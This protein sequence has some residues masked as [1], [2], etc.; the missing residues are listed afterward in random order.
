MASAKAKVSPPPKKPAARPVEGGS[1][2]AKE[3][4]GYKWEGWFKLQLWDD[5][6]FSSVENISW[7][8]AEG[9]KVVRGVWWKE[10][11]RTILSAKKFSWAAQ[12]ILMEKKPSLEE[13][14]E[15]GTHFELPS[16]G[17]VTV[18]FMMYMKAPIVKV[19]KP[20]LPKP[21]PLNQFKDR[22]WTWPDQKKK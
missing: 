12:Y 17:G 15:E 7:D 19:D 1:F 14:E 20:P 16:E 2:T 8:T 4:N 10:G 21:V 22:K 3:E 6:T 5:G 18:P 9:A 13:G 11:E